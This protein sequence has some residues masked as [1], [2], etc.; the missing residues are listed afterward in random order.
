ME[1]QEHQNS[2]SDLEPTQPQNVPAGPTAKEMAAAEEA[3]ALRVKQ[4]IE[5]EQTQ[6]EPVPEQNILSLAAQGMD[7]LHEAIRRHSNQPTH[8]DY[9]PPPRTPRQM[10][11]LREELEAGARASARAKEQQLIAQAARAKAAAEDRAKEGFTTP[12]HR[13]GDVVPDPKVPAL[14]GSVAGTRGFDAPRQ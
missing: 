5:R 12:V 6:A 11:A 9:A 10:E 3:N 14:N 4:R 8:P 1:A 13:P 7:V 2:A